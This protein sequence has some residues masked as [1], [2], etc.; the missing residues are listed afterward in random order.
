[1]GN[2]SGIYA[3]YFGSPDISPNVDAA[4]TFDPQYGFS[5]GRKE[6]RKL[7]AVGLLCFSLATPTFSDYGLS[8]QSGRY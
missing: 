8:G 5:H 3:T 4:P 2:V 6:R 7:S 1:M